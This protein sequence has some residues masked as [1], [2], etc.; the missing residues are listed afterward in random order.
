MLLIRLRNSLLYRTLISNFLLVFLSVIILLIGLRTYYFLLLLIIYYYY[1]YRKNIIIFKIIIILNIIV[2][3]LYFISINVIYDYRLDTFTGIVSN[4]TNKDEYNRIEVNNGFVKVIGYDY[5][6]SNIN[7]SDRITIWGVN[8]EM[9][10]N[11]NDNSF[12]YKEYLLSKRT[13][14]I[15]KIASFEKETSINIYT[16]RR[17]LYTYL[18]KY[19]NDISKTYIKALVLGDNADISAETNEGLRMNGISHLFS[20]SGLHINIIIFG[21]DRILSK[22][23]IKNKNKKISIALIIYLFITYFQV[24]IVRGVFTYLLCNI[25][26]KE[27]LRISSL[28]SLSIVGVLL[29]LL[30]PLLITNSSFKLSFLASF[31]ITIYKHTTET[32]KNEDLKKKIKKYNMV[33]MT[34]VMQITMLPFIAFNYEMNILSF[35]TNVLFIYIVNFAILPITYVSLFFF[36][37]SFLLDKLL[38]GF[39][40]VNSFFERNF[41][42]L[43]NI[44]AFS[45]LEI[46]LFYAFIYL[47]F[48]M[49]NKRRVAITFCLFMF[50]L[51][52][53]TK[54]NIFG[55]VSFLCLYEGDSILID[56][57]FN[58]GIILIDTG[59]KNNNEVINNLKSK[60]IKKIDYLILTHN[61]S[62]HNG[63]ANN[64]INNFNVSNVVMSAYDNNRYIKSPNISY[65]KK[66]DIISVSGYKFYVLNPGIDH[67]DENND[68]IVLYTKLG[69]LKYLFMGDCD[70]K[71]EEELEIN[72]E[73]NIVKIGHHGSST[74]TSL[75]FL[76]KVFN[77]NGDKYALITSGKSTKY[78]FPSELTINTLSKIDGLKVYD[79]KT[80]N[81]ICVIF[82]NK[83]SLIKSIK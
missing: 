17:L 29:L 63:E 31:L 52:N 4:I 39:E 57:P 12:N 1:I 46:L 77:H 25:S 18:E 49:K 35:L 34:L 76:N 71:T 83:K 26:L 3:I 15:V 5:N 24:S 56:L 40:F 28:D 36:P 65:V 42:V 70:K 14:S 81:E 82:G 43:V 51:F 10:E 32:I 7:I 47:L 21:L 69:N 66:N 80:N 38:V 9:N 6:K 67:D 53:K 41:S 16:I 61:H 78:D 50:L 75:S 22:L 13:I 59:L 2:L 79:T 23:K 33:I 58:K 27:D 72:K 30:N 55:K 54:L 19:Y 20:I 11:F 37:L 73:V 8:L 48:V 44:P 68:S 62:D 74:S 45:T 64:I 60:G